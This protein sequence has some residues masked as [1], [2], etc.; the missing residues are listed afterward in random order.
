MFLN[1]KSD[2]LKENMLYVGC[3]NHT[4]KFDFFQNYYPKPNK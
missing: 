3:Y 1:L 4:L 2:S